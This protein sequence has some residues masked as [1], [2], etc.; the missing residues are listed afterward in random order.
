MWNPVGS[1]SYLRRGN[2]WFGC[3]CGFDCV[4]IEM[5]VEREDMLVDADGGSDLCDGTKTC[6]L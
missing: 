5:V 3:R 2:E 1:G 6:A 4:C